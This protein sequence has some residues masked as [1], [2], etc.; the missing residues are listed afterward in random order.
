MRTILSTKKLSIPQKERLL[1]AGLSVVDVDFIKTESIDFDVRTKKVK[2]AIFTSQNGVKSVL[3]QS[4][5]IKNTFCVGKRTKQLLTEKGYKIQFMA[6]NAEEL[7]SY[8]INNAVE[9]EFH[10]FCAKDRLDTLPNMLTENKIVWNEVPV[11]KTIL[12][13]KNYP[14]QFDGVL[15]F[16]PSGVESFF[17]VN[18]EL[19]YGFCIGN[20]TAKALEKYSKQ[21]KIATKPTIENVLVKVIKHY[22]ND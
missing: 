19:N 15:F 12:T 6:L 5:E 20:T 17:K 16:S 21:Y 9:K 14:Q 22:T 4:I 3:N 2:N 10:Y 1:N 18:S 7:G 13:P 8:I 11:Y